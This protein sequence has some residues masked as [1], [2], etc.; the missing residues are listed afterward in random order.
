MA[1]TSL[2]TDQFKATVR[3]FSWKLKTVQTEG[4]NSLGLHHIVIVANQVATIR[5]IRNTVHQQVVGLDG[6][7]KS[8]VGKSQRSFQR[9]LWSLHETVN[10]CLQR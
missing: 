6:P 7:L 8:T 5:A 4:H 3:S 9:Y 2:M 1:R 10:N